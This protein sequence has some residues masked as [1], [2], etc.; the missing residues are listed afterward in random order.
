MLYSTMLTSVIA[1]WGQHSPE[2]RNRQ[3]NRKYQGKSKEKS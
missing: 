1:M 2:I 3:L